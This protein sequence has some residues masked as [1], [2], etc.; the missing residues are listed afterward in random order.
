[1][2]DIC[3]YALAI[4]GLSKVKGCEVS[5]DKIPGVNNS[6]RDS[7]RPCDKYR[8][9]YTQCPYFVK[10]RERERMLLAEAQT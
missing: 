8:L 7:Y 4:A 6:F 3:P 5:R 10:A 2:T 9:D 1:M